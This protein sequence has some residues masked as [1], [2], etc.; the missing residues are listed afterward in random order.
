MEYPREALYRYV[1]TLN[2]AGEVVDSVGPFA[3]ARRI[4]M[5]GEPEPPFPRNSAFVPWSSTLYTATSDTDEFRVSDI[6]TG[7]LLRIVRGGVASRP[8]TQRDIDRA[9]VGHFPSGIGEP[10]VADLLPYWTDF[11]VDE[12]GWVWRRTYAD[13]DADSVRWVIVSADAST[14]AS[15]STV[16]S[17]KPLHISATGLLAL[18]RDSLDV[19]SVVWYEVSRGGG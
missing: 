7:D 13:P 6:E 12:L 19:E 10:W 3:G 2:Q 11:A 14:V 1:Y 4:W 16:L 8:P 5:S 17:F 18:E 9:M 15:L